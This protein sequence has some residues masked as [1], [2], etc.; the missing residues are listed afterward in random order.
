MKHTTQ[1]ILSLLIGLS[2]SG[3]TQASS[4]DDLYRDVIRSDNDGYLPMFVKN[5]SMP[6]VLVEE[7]VLKKAS[8][9]PHSE[10]K[11]PAETINLTNNFQAIDAAKR[12]KQ[13]KWEHTLQAVQEN[14]V[15]PLDLDEITYR[16]SL[17]DPKAIEVL[18]WMYTKG[19]GVS[20]NLVSAF[21]LYRQA[22]RLNVPGAEENA[23]KVYQAMNAEQRSQIKE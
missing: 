8:S 7:E 2:Y 4:L 12:A 20:S 22:E 11:G 10:L 14:R 15:T 21:R 13:L 1:I 19:V 5:R 17:S 3:L 16:V 6:D 9:Q 18:A 23:A